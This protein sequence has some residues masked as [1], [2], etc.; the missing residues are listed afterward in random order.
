MMLAFPPMLAAL[1]E[2]VKLS[3]KRAANS[4]PMAGVESGDA[5]SE[6]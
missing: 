4:F 2:Y 6:T 1:R 5:L 3:G